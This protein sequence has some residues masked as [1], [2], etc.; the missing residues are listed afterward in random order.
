MSMPGPNGTQHVMRVNYRSANVFNPKQKATPL[1]PAG[2]V[3]FA[4]RGKDV[5]GVQ[6][7]RPREQQGAKLDTLNSFGNFETVPPYKKDGVFYPFGRVLRGSTGFVARDKAFT[8]MVDAQGQQPQIDI[9]TSWLSVGHVDE[10]L[11]FVKAPTPRGWA[12]LANDAR[13][14]MKMLAGACER[15][16]RQSRMFTGY[17]W[18]TST[19]AW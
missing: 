14:A 1:R 3:V 4:L 19:P 6:S 5:A 15:R 8:K 12:M 17:S 7:I 13:L 9:D 10:T 18:S 11:S 2:R 16:A